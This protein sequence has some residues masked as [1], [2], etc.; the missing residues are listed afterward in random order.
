MGWNAGIK[1]AG[2]RNGGLFINFVPATAFRACQGNRFGNAES[3]E[4][5][6]VIGDLT[7]NRLCARRQIARRPKTSGRHGIDFAIEPAPGIQS[8]AKDQ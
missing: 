8:H 5:M 6:P 1:S 7:A 4:V 3:M 2:P